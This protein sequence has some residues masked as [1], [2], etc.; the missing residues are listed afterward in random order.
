MFLIFHRETLSTSK[1]AC[2]K[3]VHPG[4]GSFFRLDIFGCFSRIILFNDLANFFESNL[5]VSI[6]SLVV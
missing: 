2:H 3:S 6:L 5:Q 4:L 1:L